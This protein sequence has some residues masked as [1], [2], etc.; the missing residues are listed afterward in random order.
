MSTEL[1]ELDTKR[2]KNICGVGEGKGISVTDREG[3]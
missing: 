2:K 1:D 3:L